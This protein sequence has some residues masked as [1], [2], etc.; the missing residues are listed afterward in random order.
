MAIEFNT[1]GFRKVVG[2]PYP[3]PAWLP[4]IAEQNIPITI[5]SDAHTPDQLALKFDH[6]TR[7]IRHAGIRHLAKYDQ[8]KQAYQLL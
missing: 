8:R 2:E 5:G 4:L 1:S 3:D 6:M 7:I